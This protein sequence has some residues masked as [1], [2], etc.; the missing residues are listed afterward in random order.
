MSFIYIASPYTDD[1]LR[2]MRDRY[3]AAEAYAAHLL[4]AGVPCFSPIVHCHELA[5][6]HGLGK[7]SAFWRPY[8][9]SMLTAC[10]SVDFLLIDG[11]SES[12]G[13]FDELAYITNDEIDHRFIEPFVIERMEIGPPVFELIT[14]YRQIERPA[15][16]AHKKP[17]AS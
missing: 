8:N 12:V 15:E 4:A 5:R 14:G 9:Y 16:F 10:M 13:L 6:R 1:D 7:E 3:L 11:W 2:V 17:G